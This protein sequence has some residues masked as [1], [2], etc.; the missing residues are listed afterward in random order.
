[1]LTKGQLRPQIRL[2]V[3]LLLAF[4]SVGV[5]AFYATALSLSGNQERDACET[6]SGYASV[7]GGQISGEQHELALAP[8]LA[9]AK[10]LGGL[11][12]RISSTAK[13]FAAVRSV[14][15]LKATDVRV[16]DPEFRRMLL[17]YG[18]ELPPA[19]VPPSSVLSRV[20]FSGVPASRIL[21][22]APGGPTPVA[23]IPLLNR[24]GVTSA[25]LVVEGVPDPF[26]LLPKNWGGG[27]WIVLGAL[28]LASVLC[29]SVLAR[30]I[31]GNPGQTKWT[32]SVRAITRAIR[33]P[34]L[35]FILI[36]STVVTLISGFQAVSRWQE[37]S[38]E[39][40][41][42][43][44]RMD[45][46]D[47][48]SRILDRDYL[49]VPI[50]HD[51][52]AQEAAS[53]GLADFVSGLTKDR[54]FNSA[55]DF[56]VVMKQIRNLIGD[57][58]FKRDLIREEQ[59]RDELAARTTLWVAGLMI[60][61]SIILIRVAA[62]QQAD[63]ESA[64]MDSARFQGA[65]SQVAENLPI[66]LFSYQGRAFKFTNKV[67]DQL[68][69][70]FPFE[71]RLEALLRSIHPEDS[72]RLQ[73]ALED[74]ER[75]RRPFDIQYRLRRPDGQ[76]SNIE[77]RA[78]PIFDTDG[79]FE[80][81]LGFGLDITEMMRAQEQ[82]ERQNKEV[83]AKNSQLHKALSDIEDNFEAMVH[84]LVKAVEAKDPYTAGHSERVMGYSVRIGEEMGLSAK[85]LRI[86]ERGAL[87]HDI[88]KI[89]VPDALL[90]KP[91]AL[92]D[93][94][95][96]IV[97]QH[98]MIG[99]RMIQGI[100]IFHECVPIV[101]WHHE[102]LDGKGYPDRLSGDQIPLLVRITAVAD[103]FDAM[104]SNRAYR[105]GMDVDRALNL[106]RADAEGGALDSEIVEVLVK[107]VHR[108]GL[109]WQATDISA[110]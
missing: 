23:Y 4:L 75:S 77:S 29:T 63:L 48:L 39:L 87:V 92:T 12:A 18:K 17:L 26:H 30:L 38:K 65:Y 71:N 2:S 100:P 40:Q 88:G 86:L 31:L 68:T 8:T 107:V 44:H 98:P 3:M 108:D 83:S 5:T 28:I 105:K 10:K 69:N 42:L 20:F 80:Y 84:S 93:E 1:M 89:G 106:L 35:E 62:A 64:E 51:A 58:R 11:Q 95:F 82:V 49:G 81:L 19:K 9:G 85:Q 61:G 33:N 60:L 103:C 37:A 104:T 74:G 34:I 97:K 59:E 46:L 7:L 21:E 16:R 13:H 94:E 110:A 27:I 57:S 109:L 41:A 70:R 24:K 6:L 78:V 15:T 32:R 102:R 76:E 55:T 50:A 101:L 53:L 66:G 91:S 22:G 25:V 45:R 52:L 43:E 90:T 72:V 73:E 99:F 67:W 47:D 96:S 36:A 56:G 79:Q 14:Y 54:G